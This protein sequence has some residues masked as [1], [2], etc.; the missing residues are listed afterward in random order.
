M[1]D[2]K[3]LYSQYDPPEKLEQE[4]IQVSL[5][6]GRKYASSFED[7]D[8]TLKPIK[9]QNQ[10]CDIWSLGIIILE[11]Y[12]SLYIHKRDCKDMVHNLYLNK[13]SYQSRC[14][15]INEILDNKKNPIICS[16]IKEML[17]DSQGTQ[18]TAANSP[19]DTKIIDEKTMYDELILNT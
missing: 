2:N 17:R 12:L 11:V 6:K 14:I 4:S 5:K 19:E 3:N 18:N 7:Y 13:L 16:L 10:N 1:K 9:L 15:L 8:I